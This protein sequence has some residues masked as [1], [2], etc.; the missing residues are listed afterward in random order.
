ME[1]THTAIV[2]VLVAVLLLLSALATRLSGR[3]G[4]PALLFFLLLGSLARLLPESGF[5]SPGSHLAFQIGTVALVLIL[6]DGGLR[7]TA[8]TARSVLAPALMLALPGTVISAA[9]LALIGHAIGLSKPHAILL[10]AIVS[11]TDVAAVLLVLRGAPAP[12]GE[13]VGRTL[14][15]E[16]A[17]NDPVAVILTTSAIAAF[18]AKSPTGMAILATAIVQIAVGLMVGAAFGAVGRW[19]LA[20]IV[21]PSA[22][23]YP[24]LTVSLALGA[25]G[26]ATIARGSGFLAVALLAIILAS[27]SLPYRAGLH[28]VHDALA[29][30]SQITMFL[31][32]GLLARPAGLVA[33]EGLGAILALALAIVARPASVLLCLVP[34]RFTWRERVFIAVTGLRGAVPIVL[35][36]YPLI[37]GVPSAGELFD[38]VLVMVAFN[39]LLPGAIVGPLARWLRIGVKAP[40]PPPAGIEMVSRV[41][42]D[43]SFMSY[44]VS[45]ASAVAGAQVQELPLPDSTIVAL[46]ARGR[47]ILAPRGTTRLEPGDHVYVF[48][49]RADESFVDL[50]FGFIEE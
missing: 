35:A 48:V 41:D 36:T 27:G 10:G 2:L 37:E 23:L 34:F 30:L 12:L 47:Q 39:S 49:T 14:E 16:S 13:R 1:P 3:L 44:Y 25:F 24:V 45:P 20:R 29:W 40:P 7:I 32:L 17:L 8:R 28:R 5:R 4:I 26:V 6:F 15:L 18:G 46:I 33:E 42:Y 50:L 19:M 38:L 21:L 31:L 11:S 9:L 43:G 22:G